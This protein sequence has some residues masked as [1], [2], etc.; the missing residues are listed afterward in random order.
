M[1]KKKIKKRKAAVLAVTMII[2]G[3]VLAIGLGVSVVSI[4]SNKA[5]VSS[6]KSNLAYSRADSGVE[7]I[8]LKIKNAEI[9]D[10]ISE[11]TSCSN[12]IFN[13]SSEGYKIEFKDRNDNFITDCEARVTQIRAIKSTG[14]ADDNQRVIEVAVAATDGCAYFNAT[15][16]K[17][18]GAEVGGYDGGNEKC[19]D[20]FPDEDGMRMCMTT[21]FVNGTPEKTGWYNT[22]SSFT[23]APTF[24]TMN[25]CL[26]WT[27]SKGFNGGVFGYLGQRWKDGASGADWCGTGNY[28]LC[29]KCGE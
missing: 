29:C 7:D 5:S 17:Y 19:E 18:K 27:S 8:L 3:L 6:N 12:G 14:K 23:D 16:T 21:D 26:G 20:A 2:L 4:M 24:N 13:N 22:F 10:R 25:D 11:I 15:S 9:G 28:I 1:Q